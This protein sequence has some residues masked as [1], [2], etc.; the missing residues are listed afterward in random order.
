[1]KKF[2]AMLA[3]GVALSAGAAFADTI[4]NG[5]GNTFV[6]TLG[7]GQSARY[8]FDAD[9]T[10]HATGPD[11]SAQ[12][13]RYEQANGQLCFLGEGD[14]RQCAPLVSGKNVGD[15]WQQTDANGNP[16][17]VTIEAGR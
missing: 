6:V 4:E 1:M 7:N 5:Y 3:F 13:G 14:A 9:G 15:T 2:A 8:H 16:I 10:F 12:T 11:G 17:T